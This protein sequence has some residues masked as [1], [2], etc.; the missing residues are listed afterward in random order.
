MVQRAGKAGPLKSPLTLRGESTAYQHSFG[1][2]IESPIL[3]TSE[4]MSLVLAVQ[5]LCPSLLK[6][7]AKSSVVRDLGFS[8]LS[9][10]CSAHYHG[11]FS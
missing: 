7:S 11:D 10:S 6:I 3:N 8:T 9:S 5:R 2:K 1:L 4:T